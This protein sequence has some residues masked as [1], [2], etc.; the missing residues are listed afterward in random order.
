MQEVQRLN[1]N[2]VE[3]RKFEIRDCPPNKTPLIASLFQFVIENENPMTKG[4]LP[5]D[6]WFISSQVSS[7]LQYTDMRT[8]RREDPIHR[9]RITKSDLFKVVNMANL[10]LTNTTIDEVLSLCKSNYGLN[11]IDSYL[12]NVIIHGSHKPEVVP[13]KEWI[14]K[15]VIP[16]I[17]TFGS[18]TDVA[19]SQQMISNMF[20][21]LMYSNS[22]EADRVIDRSTFTSN[23]YEYARTNGYFSISQDP[24]LKSRIINI[25][26]IMRFSIPFFDNSN[27]FNSVLQDPINIAKKIGGTEAISYLNSKIIDI[28]QD[29]KHGIPLEELERE[30]YDRLNNNIKSYFSVPDGKKFMDYV[31]SQ[32]DIEK[33][34]ED[35]MF[36]DGKH[37]YGIN[38][39]KMVDKDREE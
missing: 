17:I 9:M 16:S 2:V 11:L 7:L 31:K 37:I 15:T 8:V 22:V 38:I 34:E 39:D 18:Y 4:G 19:M 24:M 26:S 5:Y 6:S 14:A 29:L 21:N 28:I 33:Q 13:F 35:R 10:K 36:N 27:P 32:N 1:S 23:D 30:A 12:L 3:I 20:N 25:A